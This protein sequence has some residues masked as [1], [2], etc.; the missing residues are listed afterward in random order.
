MYKKSI[1]KGA[2]ILTAANLITRVMG[3]FYRIYMSDAI[4]SE[5]IGLYQLV[6]PIYL[7]RA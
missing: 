2:I 5:G 7:L 4:V 3:F 6:M 1:V